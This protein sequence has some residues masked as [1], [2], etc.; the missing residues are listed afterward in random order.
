VN[1]KKPKNVDFKLM[2]PMT[3]M[4][5]LPNEPNPLEM[6]L[7]EVYVPQWRKCY[8]C[9]KFGTQ[10]VPFLQYFEELWAKQPRFNCHDCGK[11]PKTYT[12]QNTKLSHLC[13]LQVA[14]LWID[15]EF[16]K[17]WFFLFWVVFLWMFFFFDRMI[18]KQNLL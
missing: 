7:N 11:Q 17:V 14:K 8:C 4:T 18:L 6:I 1:K 12:K 13:A 10:D 9:R 15:Q 2:P 16:K 5:S 3:S